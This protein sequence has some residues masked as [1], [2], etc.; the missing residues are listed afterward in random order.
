MALSY[1]LTLSR[2]KGMIGMLKR[3]MLIFLLMCGANF[4]ND[5]DCLVSTEL[6]YDIGDVL[7]DSINLDHNGLFEYLTPYRDPVILRPATI[8]EVKY[9]FRL[10]GGC[11]DNLK[12]IRMIIVKDSTFVTPEGLSIGQPLR[13][14]LGFSNWEI[15]WM[16]NLGK[17]YVKLPSGWN[18]AG[19]WKDLKDDCTKIS[20]R[21][22]NEFP[23]EG[24][25]I[26]YFFKLGESQ[27]FEEHEEAFKIKIEYY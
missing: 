13:N 25:N 10:V 8:D 17:A 19:Y 20:Q 6:P 9:Y 4:A 1:K 5:N 18:A 7:P 21:T 15:I 23:L 11:N 24:R 2:C 14:A 22:N 12:R 27:N 26:E 3:G 16:C